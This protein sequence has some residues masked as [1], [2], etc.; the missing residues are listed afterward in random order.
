MMSS[1]DAAPRKGHGTNGVFGRWTVKPRPAIGVLGAFLPDVWP[2]L[3]VLFTWLLMAA[4]YPFFAGSNAMLVFTVGSLAYLVGSRLG[5][6]G[7]WS[8]GILV[9]GYTASLFVLCVSGVMLPTL[10]AGLACWSLG[11]S[12]PAVAPAL[13]VGAL[14][15]RSAIRRPVPP[16]GVGIWWSILAFVTLCGAAFAGARQP[17]VQLAHSTSIFSHAWVQLPALVGAG[18]I[19]PGVY[20][21]LA[22]ATTVIDRA[23][24]SPIGLGDASLEDL[25]TGARD[26]AYALGMIVLIWYFFP[27]TAEVMFL[28]YWFVCLCGT[29]SNWWES[30]VHVQ[31][32]RSWIFGIAHDRSDLGRRTAARVVWRSLPWLV[33]GSGWCGIHALMTASTEAFLLKEV[34]LMQIAALLIA[35]SLCHLTRRLPPSFPCRK[36]VEALLVGLGAGL[37]AYFLYDHHSTS[38]TMLIFALIVATVLTVVVGGRALARAEVTSEIYSSPNRGGRIDTSHHGLR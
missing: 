9:P 36:G 28:I 17:L 31:L 38:F 22:R 20:R 8:G 27:K 23:D 5:Q 29:V 30:T 34:L 19:V 3:V 24:R 21:A 2:V 18:L 7:V 4:L 33:L 26:A 25:R 37:C 32:S 35:T 16:S 13:L 12:V 10:L 14:M 1:Q 15:M 6:L 11:N